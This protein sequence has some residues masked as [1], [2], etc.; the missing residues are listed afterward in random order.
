MQKQE[1]PTMEDVEQA[2]DVLVGT[3]PLET[4]ERRNGIKESERNYPSENRADGGATAHK[5]S[6]A[7]TP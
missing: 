6:D 7:R 1:L 2:V 3:P 5:S 4:S